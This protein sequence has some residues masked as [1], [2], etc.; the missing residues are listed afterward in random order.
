MVGVGLCAPSH[1]AAAAVPSKLHLPSS[2]DEREGI[3]QSVEFEK[4]AMLGMLQGVLL[5]L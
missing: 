3:L 2:G 5:G 4:S 1:Y